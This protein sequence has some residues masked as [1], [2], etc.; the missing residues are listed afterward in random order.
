VNVV[1]YPREGEVSVSERSTVIVN[2]RRRERETRN[3]KVVRYPRE[4]EV[5][6]NGRSTGECSTDKFCVKREACGSLIG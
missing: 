2:E 5:S 4:G 6:V 3:V 1:R